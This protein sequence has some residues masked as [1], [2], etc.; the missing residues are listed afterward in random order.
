MIRLRLRI[1]TAAEWTTA[2][3]VLK[4]GEPGIE[5][6]TRK[7]KVGDGT[8]TWTG[9]G[10]M[11][12]PGGG[13]GGVTDHGDLDGLADD[14]HPL[15]LTEEEADL[16]Y[17]AIGHDHDADYAAAVHTH[18]VYLTEVE[19]DLLYAPLVHTHAHDHD[20][21]YSAIGHSHVHNHDADYSAIGHTHTHDHDGDYDPFGEADAERADH[22]SDFAHA[23]LHARQHALNS[24]SDHTGTL[25]DGQIP[26]GV[27]RD[28][29]HTAIGDAAPHHPEAHDHDLEYDA[30]GEAE[31][32]RADH[33]A[34]FDHSALGPHD[35]D[36]DDLIPDLV[37]I[38][39][40]LRLA[41]R[42]DHTTTGTQHDVTL[43]D[44]GVFR[45]SGAGAATI[46]GLTGGAE[47]RLLLVENVSGSNLTLN[48]ENTSS[49]A[50]NRFELPDAAGMVIGTRSAALFAYDATSSRWR[51][52][53]SP[54]S[55]SSAGANITVDS[56]GTG[57]SSGTRPATVGHGHRLNSADLAGVFEALGAAAAAIATHE[58]AGNPHAV[59]LTQAEADAL[60]S[61]LAH[62][63]DA[64]YVNE[65]D[66]TKAAHDALDIDADTLDGLTSADF[67]AQDDADFVELTDGSETTLHE[68]AGSTGFVHITPE[69]VISDTGTV[70]N[71]DLTLGT[72]GRVIW[73][74]GANAT[75][76]GFVAPAS[77]DGRVIVVRNN[78]AFL[79]TLAHEGAASTATNRFTL[80]AAVDLPLSQEE[81]ATFLYEGDRWV[82]IGI[83]RRNVS[84]EA[85][86]TVNTTIG[87]SPTD[88]TGASVALTP[89]TWLILGVIVIRGTTNAL[90]RANGEIVTSANVMVAEGSASGG[91][92]GT[93]NATWNTISL[94]AIVTI[95]ANTTYKLRGD[96]VIGAN[97][98][99][100]AGADA[101]GTSD[102]GTDKGTG[103]RAIRL[104]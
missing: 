62:H 70:N 34:D 101:S 86:T 95:T 49:T 27:M 36:E 68:H 85:F 50:G 47:G 74:G 26:A 33:E 32:E 89:G 59:Y 30:L 92:G 84:V 28:A 81:E 87:S 64:T 37:V 8:T 82:C 78:T 97:P 80:P 5:S 35:H 58:G 83:A 22:E 94:S 48:H 43:N 41:G 60:Y 10:Y 25:D 53:G 45:Y 17:E 23:L 2:N 91:A 98:I 76:T 12:A 9:L 16:L 3:P 14:D 4:H 51:L 96:G 93:N 24:G 56:A 42:Q 52:I 69:V 100:S 72:N 6:D 29:E 19:A 31:D 39:E 73:Q 57:G 11:T 104:V 102:T 99:A 38:E 63:H 103:I 21:D 65:A 67:V 66:H 18:D 55:V 90:W 40:F 54:F 75:Y 1:G 88:I 46:S 71:K 44:V 77:G 7:W 79:L 13:G 15:Y 20:G 61:V